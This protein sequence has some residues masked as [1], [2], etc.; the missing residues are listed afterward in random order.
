MRAIRR[1][2]CN[3]VARMGLQNTTNHE[4]GWWRIVYLKQ[5][6]NCTRP[7]KTCVMHASNRCQSDVFFV[8]ILQRWVYKTHQT[9]WMHATIFCYKIV[10]AP[11]ENLRRSNKDFRLHFRS[12]FK[13]C[14]YR[15]WATTRWK[16][17]RKRT[18]KCLFDLSKWSLAR[19]MRWWSSSC[20]VVTKDYAMFC[21]I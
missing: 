12:T 19:L 2:L 1:F 15:I 3:N 21:A 17:L 20:K 6:T 4:K 11:N 8:T 7:H 5:H 10:S 14:E 13:G 16:V 18:L 9:Y